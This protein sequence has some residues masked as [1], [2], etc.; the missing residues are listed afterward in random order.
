MKRQVNPR[1]SGQI[2][3]FALPR[4]EEIPNVGLYLEQV[5]KY[6]CEYLAPLQEGALTGSMISNYVKKGLLD[7]PVKKQYGR[8]QIA[9]LFFIA[10]AKNVLSLDELKLF[11]ERQK[12]T[13]LPKVAYDYF[14]EELENVLGFVF[15]LKSAA[16]VVGVENTQEKEMLRNTIVAAVHKFYLQKYFADINI[17]SNNLLQWSAKS[18]IIFVISDIWR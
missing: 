10:V 17:I 5:T 13:Y 9:Y 15:G 3:N 16:D 4:Y 18:D 8:E 2:A 12:K 14:C 11:I 1:I 6:I 7:N